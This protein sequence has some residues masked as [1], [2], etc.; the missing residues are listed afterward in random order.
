MHN[1]KGPKI[2][3]WGTA[4]ARFTRSY[5]RLSIR[6]GRA[7]QARHSLKHALVH[8]AESAS[9][10]PILTAIPHVRIEPR[11]PR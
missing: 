5:R 11:P 9:V 10:S 2:G 1:D 3:L 8:Q 7:P 6:A 4:S